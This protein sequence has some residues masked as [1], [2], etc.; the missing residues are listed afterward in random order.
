MGNNISFP[1]QPIKWLF[2]LSAVPRFK[3]NRSLVGCVF[4]RWY[5][6]PGEVRQMAQEGASK[7][8]GGTSFPEIIL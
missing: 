2:S 5:F 3:V 1:V 6:S 4:G 8:A 7:M